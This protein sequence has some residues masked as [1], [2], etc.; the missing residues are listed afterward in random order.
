MNLA[1]IVIKCS[2]CARSI[3]NICTLIRITVMTAV[4][5]DF[6]MEQ[7]RHNYVT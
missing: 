5:V 6:F 3:K 4:K 2:N 7:T 1:L